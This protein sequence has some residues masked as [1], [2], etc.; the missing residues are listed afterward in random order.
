MFFLS[1]MT[2]LSVSL[3]RLRWCLY[4]RLAMSAFTAPD[5][6]KSSIFL[7]LLGFISFYLMTSSV[8]GFMPSLK[9]AALNLGEW[10]SHLHLSKCFKLLIG[11]SLLLST[12]PSSV[13]SMLFIKTEIKVKINHR[14]LILA[15]L[16]FLLE[17][18]FAV[19]AQS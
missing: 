5:S 14:S 7:K 11:I 4:H 12:K 17:R 19:F 18:A 3:T 15:F 13:S 9:H 2:K 10:M 16:I 8:F 6:L 1:V